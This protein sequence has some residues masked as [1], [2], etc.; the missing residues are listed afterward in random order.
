MGN[1]S[2]LHLFHNAYMVRYTVLWCPIEEDEHSGGRFCG[3]SQR[4][5]ALPHGQAQKHGFAVGLDFFVD[6][7]FQWFPPSIENRLL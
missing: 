4:E 7:Y 6:F 3:A 5:T 2:I 1:H